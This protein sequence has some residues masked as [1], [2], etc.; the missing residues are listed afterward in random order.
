MEPI[1]STDPVVDM[2][3][4]DDG[5]DPWTFTFGE[6]LG[7]DLGTNPEC[8]LEISDLTCLTSA[9][10]SYPMPDNFQKTPNIEFEWPAGMTKNKVHTY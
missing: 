10:N 3:I 2:Y 4:T 8:V 5:S 7:M 6:F 1:F 9:D